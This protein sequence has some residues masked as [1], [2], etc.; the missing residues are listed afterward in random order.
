MLL[1][2]YIKHLYNYVVLYTNTVL[3]WKV[4]NVIILT[5]IAR[6]VSGGSYIKCYL[7]KY[8]NVLQWIQNSVVLIILNNTYTIYY[9]TVFFKYYYGRNNSLINEPFNTSTNHFSS[10]DRHNKLRNVDLEH[11]HVYIVKHH[12]H[13]LTAKKGE[14]NTNIA[15]QK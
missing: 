7:K 12:N 6:L 9:N 2:F 10:N 14:S 15:Y 11:G 3:I 1:I 4:Y 5:N 13:K 8:C